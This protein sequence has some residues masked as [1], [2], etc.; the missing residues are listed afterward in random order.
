MT[1]NSRGWRSIRP[2]VMEDT[3]RGV[4]EIE[5]R[6]IALAGLLAAMY[7]VVVTTLQPI[8]FLES[9]IRVAD[10]LLPLSIIFGWPAIVG[11]TLGTV[12]AN[13]TSPF[14]AID[15]GGGTLANFLATYAAWKIG[16][17]GFRGSWI[18][19]IIAQNLLVTVV[20]GSY[21]SYLIGLPLEITLVGVFI[22]SLIAMNL[23]GYTLLRAVHLRLKKGKLAKF[24][25]SKPRHQPA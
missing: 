7:V 5:T 19:A 23:A 4:R 11:L 10:A 18:T 8:S 15:I 3:I 1:S 17:R 13:S 9:Q 6:D 21:L 20:V 14:G 24:L 25:L 22:G 2:L 16:S 12:I